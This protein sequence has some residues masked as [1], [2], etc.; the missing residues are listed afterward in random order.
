MNK[1]IFKAIFSASMAVFFLSLALVML[2]LYSYFNS[3]H[4]R[5]MKSELS[6]VSSAID[7]E[8]VE[9]LHGI[10]EE[11]RFTLIQADGTVVF[12]TKAD[13]SRMENH[14]EREE[15]K[16]AV[17]NGEGESTRYSD[18]LLQETTYVA[19]R[20]K[21]GSVLRIS[22]SRSSILL[23]LLR[24]AQPILWI[25]GLAF[26]ISA[27]LARKMTSQIVAPLNALNPDQPLAQKNIYPEI[28][29]LLNKIEAHKTELKQKEN[30]FIAIS[31][32]MAEGLVLLNRNKDIL[33]ANTA[34]NELFQKD[35][36]ND[37]LD[38]ALRT[39]RAETRFAKDDRQYQFI[40]TRTNHEMTTEGLVVL[41]FDITEKI[42]A[43]KFRQEFSANVSH[44][45]KTPLQSII[46]SA[47]L[48]ENGLVK[49]EDLPDFGHRINAEGKRLLNLINDIIRLSQLDEG[50][51]LQAESVRVE[52]IAEEECKALQASA[53]KK[54]ISLLLNA[55]EIE[56]SGYPQLYHEIIYNLIDNAI[57]YSA[58]ETTIQVTIRK[59]KD[60]FYISV[61]DQGI[62]IDP[63]DQDRIF[64]RFYRVDKSRSRQS[65]G[66]GL[67]LSIVKHAV[68]TMH[69]RI[70][71]NSA[72]HK[73]TEMKVIFPLKEK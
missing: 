15:F 62:G 55:D 51:N 10:D 64:E 31:D 26:A 7:A 43:E 9:Y 60:D 70:V 57:R 59:E 40:A 66:T 47:E 48:I 25:V 11:D 3:L 68:E 2:V 56:T 38:E 61:K 52:K 71:V 32:N 67:G 53:D 5:Q 41:I 50:E 1:K 54:S 28:Q 29:P 22:S 69:G 4:I 42:N 44:E 49:K 36:W 34:G 63:K 19:K 30:E 18:T 8:G 39:G 35:K 33:T 45:L 20:L 6:L 46:G 17:M 65:G 21:D 16:E 12:D 73:G 13:A 58:E 24:L 72:L 27:F 14:R 23:L 37:L